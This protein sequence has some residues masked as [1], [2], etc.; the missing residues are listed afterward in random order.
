LLVPAII[1]VPRASD[2]GDAED[3]GESVVRIE[4]APSSEIPGFYLRQL[5]RSDVVEWYA[6][7]SLPTVVEHTSWNLRGPNDLQALYDSCE[8]QAPESP[9]RLA[10]VDEEANRL[11]GTIGFHAI[12]D[13]NRSGELAFDFAPDYWGRGIGSAMCRTVTQWSYLA[14]NF[15]RVQ[16]TVLQTNLASERVLHKCGFTYEGL[17]RGY[18]MV[19]G[20]PGDF[21]MYSRLVTDPMS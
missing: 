10:I 15:V 4:V 2:S 16:A 14:L 17:L 20:S 5:K 3:R 13:V 1:A 9:C 19:R 6:Y 21:K 11:I 12:S 8:S 18:R 7:L